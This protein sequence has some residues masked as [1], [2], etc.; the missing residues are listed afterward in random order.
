MSTDI[1]IDM[2]HG[3]S[4]DQNLVKVDVINKDISKVGEHKLVAQNEACVLVAETSYFTRWSIVGLT[5][6]VRYRRNF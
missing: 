5:N 2:G 6:N 4:V 3:G 1:R